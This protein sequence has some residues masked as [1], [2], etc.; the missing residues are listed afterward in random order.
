MT[1]G[2]ID[3]VT[4]R[5]IEHV[6]TGSDFARAL[7]DTTTMVQRLRLEDLSTDDKAVLRRLLRALVNFHRMSQR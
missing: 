3:G 2:T 1:D 7:N 4:G 5:Q 6:H